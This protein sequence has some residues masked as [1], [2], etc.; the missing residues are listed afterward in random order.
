MIYSRNNCHRHI[1]PR[2]P[3]NLGEAVRTIDLV[4]LTDQ[5]AERP[6]HIAEVRQIIS[7]RTIVGFQRIGIFRRQ[8]CLCVFAHGEAEEW[9]R[10]EGS[11]TE[12]T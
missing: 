1:F 8:D 9:E 12:F 5:N 4:V 10:I 6:I 3:Q 2:L 7:V 11:N